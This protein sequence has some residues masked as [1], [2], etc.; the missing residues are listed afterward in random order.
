M[1]LALQ[2]QVSYNIKKEDF[3]IVFNSPGAERQTDMHTNF[4]DNETLALSGSMYVIMQ[5]NVEEL[6]Q[7]ISTGYAKFDILLTS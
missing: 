7:L 2:E 4:L 1:S 3:I 6:H 5:T